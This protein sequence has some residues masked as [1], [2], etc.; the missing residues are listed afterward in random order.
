MCEVSNG[1]NGR[2]RLGRA[3]LGLWDMPTSLDSSFY[4]YSTFSL[5]GGLHSPTCISFDSYLTSSAPC[6]AYNPIYSSPLESLRPFRTLIFCGGQLAEDVKN[7]IQTQL[8]RNMYMGRDSFSSRERRA[9]K[10]LDFIQPRRLAMRALPSV[11][12]VGFERRMGW[13]ER[14]MDTIRFA[15]RPDR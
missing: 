10:T 12:Q 6:F 13:R 7:L 15:E 9:Q 14:E 1:A 4:L 5:L 3:A 8:F 11:G 2:W